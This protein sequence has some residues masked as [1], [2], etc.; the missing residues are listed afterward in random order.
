MFPVDHNIS[1]SLYFNDPDGNRLE[2]YVDGCD[3]SL[4]LTETKKLDL[5]EPDAF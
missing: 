3:P 5:T 4:I 1:Y 2:L